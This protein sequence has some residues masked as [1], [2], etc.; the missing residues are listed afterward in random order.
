VSKK[1]YATWYMSLD[2]ECPHCNEWVDLMEFPD[3]WDGRSFE[4][5]EHGTERTKDVRVNCTECRKEFRVD[6]EY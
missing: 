4:V 6:L 3:F 1:H 5:G 2:T